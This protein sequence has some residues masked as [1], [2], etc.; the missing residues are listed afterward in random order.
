MNKY[1]YSLLIALTSA[2]SLGVS[3]AYAG[4]AYI[5]PVKILE[6]TA[7]G[8]TFSGQTA[9]NVEIQIPTGFLPAGL[10]CT[11]T[12]YLTTLQANLNQNEF[13]LLLV[14]RQTNAPIYL[15]ISDNSAYT[16]YTGRCSIYSVSF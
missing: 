13:A 2:L 3:P 11:N 4:T 8:V 16:A 7:L 10:T 14:A 6:M 5:G 9:G 12:Q 1:F 15:W